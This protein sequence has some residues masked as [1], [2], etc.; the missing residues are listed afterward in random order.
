[1]KENLTCLLKFYQHSSQKCSF[2]PSVRNANISGFMPMLG[3]FVDFILQN[4][5]S[6]YFANLHEVGRE[7]IL[8]LADMTMPSEILMPIRTGTRYPAV[9][10][11]SF[12]HF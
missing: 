12:L 7:K 3:N 4:F 8:P 10:C 11:G 5:A 1:M 6:E 2:V 9:K